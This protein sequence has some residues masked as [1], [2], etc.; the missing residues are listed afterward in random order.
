MNTTQIGRALQLIDAMRH[1]YILVAGDAMM[2]LYSFGRVERL[3]P[4]AP[5]PVFITERVEERR[6]GADNVAHQLEALGCIALGFFG[7]RS[8]KQRFMVGHHPLLRI[9]SDS[10][11]KPDYHIL[12]RA[13]RLVNDKVKAVVLSDYA[14]GWLT[15]ELCQAIIQS[16]REHGV[17]VVV[18]PKG[19]NWEKYN[20]ATVICPNELEWQRAQ[21]PGTF[22][23][24]HIRYAPYILVKQGAKG[25]KICS[26]GPPEVIRARAKHV[27]DVTGAG[28]T[29]VAVIAA[30]LAVG[31]ELREAAELAVLAA[32]HVVGKVG[33]AVCPRADLEQLLTPEW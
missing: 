1:A 15:T 2:D 6:G 23:E 9:D 29:L 30:G 26:G 28:D 5:V 19:T 12:E 8:T 27:F 33:T 16:A 24:N 14:K 31:A 32:G 7:S 25:V 21:M 13:K 20:G 11:D 18:D 4:E 17:P 10:R 3:S 22:D